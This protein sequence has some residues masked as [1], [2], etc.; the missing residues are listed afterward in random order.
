[1]HDDYQ[2]CKPVEL[3]ALFQLDCLS[4]ISEKPRPFG[5]NG[6]R[7]LSVHDGSKENTPSQL[8]PMTKYLHALQTYEYPQL[9]ENLRA[10]VCVIGAGITGLNIAYQLSKA[11]KS[12]IVLEARSRGSG[13][14]GKCVSS[15][16]CM[17]VV[18]P[19]AECKWS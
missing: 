13:Q 1:M 11:G 7:C 2:Q 12:V 5:L 14:T 15:M 16:L 18:L 6:I 8:C 4:L 9:K 19:H 17:C 3:K 10:D